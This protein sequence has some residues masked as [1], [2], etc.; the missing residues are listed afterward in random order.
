M[1]NNLLSGKKV[2][3][4]GLTGQVT[5]PVAMALAKDCDLWGIARFSN[6]E[7]RKELEAA[8]ITCVRLDLAEADFS[9]LPNDFDYV[10][11]FAVSF[12]NSFDTVI[13][14]IVEGLGLLMSH[15]RN[16]RGFLHCSTTGVYQFNG[17]HSLKETDPLGDN[18]RVL[19]PTYSISKIA[20]EGM[21]RYGARQ[22][23]LPT[24]IARLNVP[25]G[26]NGGWPSFHLDMMIAGQAVPVHVNKPSS[27]NPIHEDDIIRTI[28]RL[29]EVAAVPATIVNW[30]GKDRVSVEEWCAYMG[31]L[32]GFEPEFDY[33]DQTLESVIAD[34][35]RMH[36]L[37]GE[38][39][40]DWHDGFRHMIE[41]R[42]PELTLRLDSVHQ[43]KRF[44]PDK[45]WWDKT[46]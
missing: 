33:T 13:T 27:Y 41:A 40:V 3:I 4:T 46:K 14:T 25:Y 21:A 31:K 20:A 37:I 32:T 26:N 6:S 34:T 16:A 19:F 39:Q 9:E 30:A 12:D 35:T 2:L 43:G 15:C 11:N 22:W 1:S 24:V 7:I 17:H 36:Q 5:F 28:P 18:H 8:G 23:D 42:H 45:G 29:L 38:T 10:L 44:N